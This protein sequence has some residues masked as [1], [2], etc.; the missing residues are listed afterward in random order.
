M[1]IIAYSNQ[2]T[3]EWLLNFIS[4]QPT[5]KATCQA[6]LVAFNSYSL[7]E[8][9]KIKQLLESNS[10]LRQYI[11]YCLQHCDS[12]T[13]EITKKINLFTLSHSSPSVVSTPDSQMEQLPLIYPNSIFF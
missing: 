6:F 2:S 11:Q 4:A 10:Q 13:R 3:P 1:T 5:D 9:D 7:L 8:A 12:Q